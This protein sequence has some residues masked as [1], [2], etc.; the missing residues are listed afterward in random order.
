VENGKYVLKEVVIY[1]VSEEMEKE[2]E[3]KCLP[4]EMEEKHVIEC[5][6]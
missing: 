2:H 3:I 4:K 5:L 1:C 6:L